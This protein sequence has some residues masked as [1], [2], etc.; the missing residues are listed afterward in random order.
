MQLA[1]GEKAKLVVIPTASDTADKADA[2][3]LLAPWK[4]RKVA[5][6]AVLHTRDRKAADDPKFVEPLREGTGVWFGG[7]QQSRIAEAYVGTAVERELRAHPHVLDAYPDPLPLVIEVWSPSTGSY[8][9]KVK[10]ADYQQ[11]GDLEIWFVHPYERTIRAWRRLPDGTYD[12][13]VFRHGSAGAAS[14]PRFAI[15]L[16]ELFAG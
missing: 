3:K 16:D 10:L 4:A 9:M 12:E 6:A 11:R 5:S 7:G 2:E 8:D 13:T 15:D 1:G 14:L